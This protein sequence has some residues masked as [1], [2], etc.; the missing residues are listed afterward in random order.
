MKM[1]KETKKVEKVTMEMLLQQLEEQKKMIAALTAEK[2]TAA[3]KA[4]E[5]AK[6]ELINNPTSFV[7]LLKE[8]KEKEKLE[9]EHIKKWEEDAIQKSIAWQIACLKRDIGRVLDKYTDLSHNFKIQSNDFIFISKKARK[10]FADSITSPIVGEKSVAKATTEKV[11]KTLSAKFG[12]RPYKNCL[13]ILGILAREQGWTLKKGE[14]VY[15]AE[16][17]KRLIIE[18]A[19]MS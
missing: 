9:A 11:I 13:E 2:E 8:K 19:L 10:Q 7:H 1:E 18:G 14:S 16:A 3:T 4:K 6:K 12:N 15:P 17:K 5:D